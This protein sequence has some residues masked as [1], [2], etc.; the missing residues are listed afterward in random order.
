[1]AAVL[2]VKLT[3]IVEVGEHTACSYFKD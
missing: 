3:E 2:A 1:M